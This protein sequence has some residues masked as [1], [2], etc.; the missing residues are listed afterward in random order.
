MA[1]RSSLAYSDSG[2][3]S[4]AGVAN[5]EHLSTAASYPATR[6][7]RRLAATMEALPSGYRF[8]IV[9]QRIP[10]AVVVL[11]S[12][13]LVTTQELT[14]F[15]PYIK[16]R[17]ETTHGSHAQT[18]ARTASALPRLRVG[19]GCVCC[20]ARRSRPSAS[21][22]PRLCGAGCSSR[23]AR[24]RPPLALLALVLGLRSALQAVCS[25]V[26]PPLVAPVLPSPSPRW[27][28]CSCCG[29]PRGFA[30]ASALRRCL[31]AARSACRGGA[32]PVASGLARP[33]SVPLRL[34]LR[35]CG[36][37]LPRAVGLSA[38]LL[39]ALRQGC[40]GL[41]LAALGLPLPRALRPPPRSLRRSRRAPPLRPL[42]C[43]LGLRLRLASAPP[44]RGAEASSA[45]RCRSAPPSANKRRAAGAWGFGSLRSLPV[46]RV[47]APLLPSPPSLES[48]QKKKAR[49]FPAPRLNKTVYYFV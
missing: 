12:S 2:S 30:C 18:P 16:Y 10:S 28:G 46:L 21:A 6:N 39:A 47:A 48:G 31:A 33:R 20:A 4:A 22:L 26:P 19:L 37:G 9:L 11:G 23:R 40:H 1:W 38:A 41:R 3:T 29:A 44:A 32:L 27:G 14:K 36:G 13:I 34:A 8:T 17:E 5:F 49:D 43:G 15:C 7:T 25:A 42:G 45:R 24:S 35:R